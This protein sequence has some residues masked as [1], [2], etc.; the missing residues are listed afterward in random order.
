MKTKVL[1]ALLL[2]LPG[3]AF[4]G[5]HSMSAMAK[6]LTELNHFPSDAHKAT[7]A[8]IQGSDHASD[9]EKHLAGII[10]RIAHKPGPDDQAALKK[11]LAMD[12]ASPAAKTIAK[13]ILNMNH[14]PQPDD[15]AA[16][17]AL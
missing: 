8:E 11:V 16:L 9:L 10:S 5:G 12:D 4:A 1:A 7:L 14:K 13:A 17:E 6:I 3:L 2:A 15:L